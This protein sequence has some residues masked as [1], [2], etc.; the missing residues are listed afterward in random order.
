MPADEIDPTRRP[1]PPPT[2]GV[3][4]LVDGPL[5][6][7]VERLWRLFEVE[8]GS[9]GV[10]TFDRPNLTFGGGPCNDLPGLELGVA[11]Q[12]GR[13][14]P[15]DLRI[16]GVGT[17]HDPGRAIYLAVERTDRLASIH[18][19]FD[20][21]LARTCDGPFT[22]YRPAAWVPHITL[23][24]GDLT[25]EVFESARTRLAT[26]DRTFTHTVDHIGLARSRPD[27]PGF[28]LARQWTLPRPG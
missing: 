18:R 25:E 12:V 5:G 3:M 24:M 22:L 26:Y 21:V 11:E 20:R 1:T 13:L 8:Y 9:V 10:Q 27:G 6:E 19:A 2:A 23:A 4:A 7:E 14:R 17:F 15:F 16:R 28:E